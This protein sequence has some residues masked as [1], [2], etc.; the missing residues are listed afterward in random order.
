MVLQG[1]PLGFHTIGVEIRIGLQCKDSARG[2][3]HHHN[4][5]LRATQQIPCHTLN[6]HI[7]CQSNAV[8]LQFCPSYDA[9]D[10]LK[11]FIMQLH[12]FKVLRCL[13]TGLAY[14]AISGDMGSHTGTGVFSAIGTIALQGA[15]GKDFSF[16]IQ[17]VT[18][19]DGFVYITQT[20]I[21]GIAGY[22]PS[23][24]KSQLAEVA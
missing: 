11:Q 24:Y 19:F 23:I 4:G 14:T 21:I 13:H 12:Q 16:P 2:R 10:P 17:N 15:G 9:V 3:F 6:I 20:A 7:Y 1:I 5:T 18:T 22:L 8:A